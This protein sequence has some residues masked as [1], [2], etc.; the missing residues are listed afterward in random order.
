MQLKKK[1]DQSVN[2]SDLL[3]RGNRILTE[4]RMGGTWEEGRRGGRKG[5][6]TRYRRRQE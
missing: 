1:E 5:S 4:R 6:R 3:R 2:A